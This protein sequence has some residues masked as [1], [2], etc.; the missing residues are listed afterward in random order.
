M[1]GQI[2]F[3]S[4]CYHELWNM[5]LLGLDVLDLAFIFLKKHKFFMPEED[6]RKLDPLS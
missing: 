1:S 6:K 5:G 4:G 3:F 2:Q